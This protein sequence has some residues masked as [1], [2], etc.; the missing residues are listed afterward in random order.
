MQTPGVIGVA[1]NLT[2]GAVQTGSATD[3]SDT[4]LLTRVRETVLPQVQVGGVAV[5]IGFA[6]QNGVVT[7]TG[8]L[9][10]LEQRQRVVALVRQVPG[11][12]DV[13]DQMSLSVSSSGALPPN[14]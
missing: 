5:P 9:P 14:R 10:S 12:A 2:V 8:T 3:N 4:V 13:T 7:V 6:V 11:V 1:N